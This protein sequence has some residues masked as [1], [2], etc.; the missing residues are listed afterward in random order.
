MAEAVSHWLAFALLVGA[1]L[2]MGSFLGVL[3]LRLPEGRSL[4][5]ARSACPRCGRRLAAR[6]LVPLL[7][8]LWLRGRCR[9]CGA[10]MGWFYPAVELAAVAV[11]LSAA[12]A[13]SGWLLWASCGL[14][15]TLLALALIDLRRFLL[16]D[17][18][19]LPLIPA[20]LVVAWL[21]APATLAD[22]AIGAA[23]GFAAFSFIAWA[24]RRWRGRDGLGGGDAKLLA[25][26]G[27]WVAWPAVPSVV[28]LAA[29]FGLGAALLGW[30]G[31]RTLRATDRLPFGPCLAAAGWIVWLWGPL[32]PGW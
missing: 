6:D 12:A 2:A 8:W 16:P 14:G 28:F 31:G 27:A 11:A 10:P 17:V 15:W 18:L 9:Q 26:L 20:G 22:H 3:V 30:I 7:S 32:L 19:T 21:V 25:A 1:A 23:G 4:A 13:T 24:Y 29:L 5:L